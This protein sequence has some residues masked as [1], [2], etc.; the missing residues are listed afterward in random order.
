M[1]KA[2]TGQEADQEREAVAMNLRRVF[3]LAVGILAGAYPEGLGAQVPELT[4]TE[5]RRVPFDEDV[6]FARAP[7]VRRGPEGYLYGM[8]GGAGGVKGVTVFDQEGHFVR[9]IGRAGEGP[10]EFRQLAAFGW[11]GDTLW[12]LDNLLYRVSRFTLDGEFLDSWR[13]ERPKGAWA[14][15]RWSPRGVLPGQAI[16]FREGSGIASLMELDSARLVAVDR[17]VGETRLIAKWSPAGGFVRARLPGDREL[18]GVHPWPRSDLLGWDLDRSRLV[19]VSRKEHDRY[20][21]T[22]LDTRG[23]TLYRTDVPVTPR[24]VSR[25]DIE[26]WRERYRDLD[27][28]MR[29]AI[30]EATEIRDYWP[31]ATFVRVSPSGAVWVRRAPSGSLV[32]WDVLDPAGN[33]SR[34]VNLP[35]SIT[36]MDVGDGILW[37]TELGEF[38]VPHLVVV[39]L[40]R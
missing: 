18:Q 40:R 9:Q 39:D 1:Q 22:L 3:L 6:P 12:V 10:G 14:A 32:R 31:A 35:S 2:T 24:R 21:V 23:D 27:P 11:H 15:S 26:S 25:A 36:L 20:R 17:A 37:G 34:F 38:D 16:L 30:E 13:Y 19:V 4:V 8:E 5:I 33:L 7:R 28:P 29:R